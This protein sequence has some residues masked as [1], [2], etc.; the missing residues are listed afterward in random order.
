MHDIYN[1]VTGPLVWISFII[2][3]GGCLY[4]FV[5][6]AMLAKKKD[7]LVFVYMD[8]KYALRSIL[9]WLTPFGTTNMRNHPYTTVVVFVFHI[10]LIFIPFFVSAHI[11]LFNES[12]N[13]S[14]WSLPNSLSDFFTLLI[15]LSCVF[16]LLRRLRLPEVKFL[17][18]FSDYIILAIV[19]APFITGFWV[20]HQL[21]G[22]V[23]VTILHILSGEI[24]LIA[25]PFTKLNHAIFFPFV[26]G[27]TGSEFGGVR[28]AV[29][30]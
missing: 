2:F 27:Y 22:S 23:F 5:T 17:T 10:L 19:A 3:A 21:P 7:P 30:W 8:L 26:R 13:V 16:F 18:T 14:W 25:I 20:Y 12:F 4:K 11:V 1:F 24:M 29:D 6:M 28:N 9:R 15:I